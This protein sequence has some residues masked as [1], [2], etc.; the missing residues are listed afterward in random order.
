MARRDEDH[1]GNRGSDFVNIPNRDALR[2]P[3]EGK[4]GEVLASDPGRMIMNHLTPLGEAAVYN[5]SVKLCEDEYECKNDE[6]D[7]M[8]RD[9]SLK[10]VSCKGAAIRKIIECGLEAAEAYRQLIKRVGELARGDRAFI[11]LGKQVHFLGKHMDSLHEKMTTSLHTKT[12]DEVA[13]CKQQYDTALSQFQK[14]ESMAN[15]Y[16]VH[17]MYELGAT[18]LQ[19]RLDWSLLTWLELKVEAVREI[20]PIPVA[21]IQLNEQ[22]NNNR[23][24]LL[25]SISSH[26][27]TW[28]IAD[29]LN[30]IS[31]SL[32]NLTSMA[33]WSSIPPNIVFAC[34]A[35]KLK[36][37][38]VG[39]PIPRPALQSLY[40]LLPFLSVDEL[41][42]DE[43]NDHITLMQGLKTLV[44]PTLVTSVANTVVSNNSE[45]E[46]LPKRIANLTSL[47]ELRLSG[48]TSVRSLPHSI[49]QLKALTKLTLR[50][51][52]SL[53][54]LPD[55]I[56]D[57]KSLTKLVLHYCE[58]LESLPDSIGDLEALQT[59]NLESC[60]NLVSL[61]DRLGEC[62]S[63]TKLDLRLCQNLKSLP[64][65]IGELDLKD[66]TLYD[67][68]ALTMDV[69]IN[70]IVEMK[71]L[72]KLSL[73]GTN[74]SALTERIG[75]L[76]SLT[77]LDLRACENLTS[78]PD[79]F[80]NLK[81]LKKLKMQICPAG[82]NMR[83][84]L[85]AQ[86]KNQGCSGGGW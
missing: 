80:G 23:F 75:G 18:I 50:R 28:G 22:V 54:L 42:I 24:A 33:D 8:V 11:D 68:K 4:L 63:L 32:L 55:T 36:E 74:I 78:L 45:L 70:K 52:T 27:T 38:S 16:D 79:G 12:L 53:Q 83:A 21:V 85:K 76:E 56:G 19:L 7:D 29:W 14:L 37:F 71:N 5:A 77:E 13:D 9:N 72:T 10:C 41:Y 20:R 34:F 51:F 15:R 73:S 46:G 62:E 31:M 43:F 35:L 1:G 39:G 57:L 2:T 61:P 47:T 40:Q 82:Q 44:V 6:V 60:Q 84:A 3:F 58:K 86:L 65:S 67:C 59:L 69:E 25:E 81:K 17:D 66:L 48:F 30:P 49:G 64:D 26:W